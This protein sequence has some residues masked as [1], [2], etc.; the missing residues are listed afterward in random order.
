MRNVLLLLTI[1]LTNI[2]FAQN[3]LVP[4]FKMNGDATFSSNF[5]KYGISQSNKDPCLSGA[6]WY[7]W[8]P[9]LKAGFT[10]ESVGFQSSETHFLFKPNAELDIYFTANAKLA[11]FLGQNLY[12]KSENRDGFFIN[13]KLNFFDYLVYIDN[14]ANFMGTQTALNHFGFGSQTSVFGNWNWENVIGYAM[15]NTSSYSNFF[16]LKSS[17]QVKPSSILYQGGLTYNSAASQFN[18]MADPSI[19]VSATV[20]F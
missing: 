10:G 1:F 7:D 18:G 9:Q 6:F 11:I 3:S 17:L 16:H 19:Y 20:T 15:V 13:L 4:T 14:E 5:T 12:F 8:G 2:S